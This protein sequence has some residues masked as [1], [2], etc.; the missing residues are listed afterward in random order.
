MHSY[1]CEQWLVGL[2]LLRFGTGGKEDGGWCGLCRD[3]LCGGISGCCY[4]EEEE[5]AESPI[6]GLSAHQQMR[7]A[8]EPPPMQWPLG[9]AQRP[10]RRNHPGEESTGYINMMSQGENE[11]GP[12]TRSYD[13][14]QFA[15]L[16]E[17]RG[18]GGSLISG[19]VLGAGG[20]QMPFDYPYD[21][22][23]GPFHEPHA[24]RSR[25][26]VL[27]E[28][29]RKVTFG[30]CRGVGKLCQRAFVP[31]VIGIVS[32]GAVGLFGRQLVLPP[33]TAPLGW[34]YIGINKLGAA[35]VPI[36]LILLGAAL[37][38]TP[39]RGQLPPL[40]V[41]G[42]TVGR[43]I[44]MP[45]CG[46]GVA[47]LLAAQKWANIPYIVADPF[48]L[49]CLILT[50]TPTA[51]NIVVLCDLAGEN[52]RAMSAAI[53]YQYCAAPFVLPGILTLF[54]SFICRMERSSV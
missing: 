13:S 30:V 44:F 43:M 37:S 40:T 32:G 33:E 9:E 8:G 53:F 19:G 1:V 47:K 45:L 27:C 5:D 39:A 46:L 22:Y 20:P 23:T 6:M 42:I 18:G 25:L 38:K 15:E 35:A 2:A 52:R 29:T 3:C 54:I 28:L 17:S 16:G 14:Q 4:L 12:F 11:V 50:A 34:L 49:V 21:A 10:I 41:A 31:Q 51:N 7:P 24:G 48:W 36:N 26:A